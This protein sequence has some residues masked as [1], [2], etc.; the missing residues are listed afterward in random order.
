MYIDLAQS[1]SPSFWEVWS[2]KIAVFGGLVAAFLGIIQAA[3]GLRAKQRDLRWRQASV[4][5]KLN[6][7]M[8]EDPESWGAMLMLDYPGIEIELK[9]NDTI[10]PTPSEILHALSGGRRKLSDVE[11]KIRLCFDSLF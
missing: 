4:A 2:W 11:A 9:K 7:E 3:L 5:K 6:D 8:M 10:A 1:T